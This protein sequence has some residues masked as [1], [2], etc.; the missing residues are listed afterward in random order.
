LELENSPSTTDL[1][2]DLLKK[3]LTRAVFP[4]R[5]KRAYDRPGAQQELLGLDGPD[6]CETNLQCDGPDLVPHLVERQMA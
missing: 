6:G 1:Y 5:Y 4:D 3:A 2:L